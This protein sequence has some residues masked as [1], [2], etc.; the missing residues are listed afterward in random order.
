MSIRAPCSHRCRVLTGRDEHTDEFSTQFAEASAT[1]GPTNLKAVFRNHNTVDVR[2]DPVRGAKG[3]RFTP[4]GDHVK[5]FGSQGTGSG[6]FDTPVDLAVDEQGNDEQGNRLRT[7]DK[8]G[9]VNGVAVTP[10]GTILA[11]AEWTAVH[12][13]SMSVG[14]P[15]G[16]QSNTGK[17]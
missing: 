13:L 10:D 17:R 2:F 16:S 14:A 5:A 8:L 6:Q 15:R 1:P 3:Y 4:S 7:F 11:V 9:V 12:E